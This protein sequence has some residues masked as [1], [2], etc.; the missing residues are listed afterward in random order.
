MSTLLSAAGIRRKL[1]GISPQQVSFSKL[2]FEFKSKESRE[3]IERIVSTFM[4]GYHMAIEEN[5]P[6]TVVSRLESID[7]EFEDEY[8]FMVNDI[9]SSKHLNKL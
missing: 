6:Q 9:K 1:F 3:R 5:D 4:E 8:E 2:G 7:L